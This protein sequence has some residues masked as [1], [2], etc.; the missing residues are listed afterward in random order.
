MF[1]KAKKKALNEWFEIVS[2]RQ[3]T[4]T[5]IKPHTIYSVCAIR[6]EDNNFLHYNNTFTRHKNK[7]GFSTFATLVQFGCR[8]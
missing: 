5:L 2:Y 8:S 7:N 4:N 1:E 3:H 6:Y